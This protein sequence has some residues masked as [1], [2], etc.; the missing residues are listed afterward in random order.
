MAA[1]LALIWAMSEGGIFFTS[2]RARHLQVTRRP[3]GP[4]AALTFPILVLPLDSRPWPPV[5][6]FPP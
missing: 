5:T 3:D 4:H 1:T 6:P 2:C